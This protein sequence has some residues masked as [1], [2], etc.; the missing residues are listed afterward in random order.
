MIS[1][2]NLVGNVKLGMSVIILGAIYFIDYCEIHLLFLL[3][4]LKC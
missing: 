2:Y 4:C 3:I 1:F